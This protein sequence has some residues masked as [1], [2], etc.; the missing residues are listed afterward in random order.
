MLNES[1]LHRDIKP[2]NFLISS[3]YDEPI[4][5]D[6]GISIEA[7]T[8]RELFSYES[9]IRGTKDYMAPELLSIYLSDSSI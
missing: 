8:N 5:I 1:V 3:F 9:I 7:E 6:F 4:I 2:S